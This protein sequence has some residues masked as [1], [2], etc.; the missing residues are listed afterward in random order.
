VFTGVKQQ[1][2]N[3]MGK[4]AGK[5]S[6]DLNSRRDRA[7]ISFLRAGLDYIAALDEWIASAERTTAGNELKSARQRVQIIEQT[8]H[9][10]FPDEF[11]DTASGAE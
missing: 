10:L 2:E 4:S 11:A 8:L 5:Q 3:N 9:K 7:G 6:P 1:E